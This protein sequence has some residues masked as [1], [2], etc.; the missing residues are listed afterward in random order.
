MIGWG[1]M[2]FSGESNLLLVAFGVFATLVPDIDFIIWLM[3]NRW[4]VD[5]FAHEH[6]DLFHKPLVVGLGGGLLIAFF[7]PLYGL[8]WFFG[9]MAHFVHDTFD[10]GWGIRWL[11]PFYFGYFTLAS[12]SPQRHFRNKTEQ[13][14]I[15]AVHGNPQWLEEEYLKPNKKRLFEVVLLVGV[16]LIIIFWLISPYGT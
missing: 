13:R 9:T 4:R 6:R 11:Y 8:V 14:A 10:G 5:Q 1:A 3:R 16:F 12:Y 2:L 15:A 7:N